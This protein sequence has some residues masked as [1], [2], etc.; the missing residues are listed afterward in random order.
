M[1]KIY[2]FFWNLFC[3]ANILDYSCLH[4]FM[5][6]LSLDITC[7]LALHAFFYELFLWY[8]LIIWNSEARFRQ[9]LYPHKN[10]RCVYTKWKMITCL[11]LYQVSLTICLSPTL[12]STQS[13]TYVGEIVWNSRG[14]TSAAYLF[15]FIYN[16]AL[17]E[18]F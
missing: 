7:H 1:Q 11:H 2:F 6:G 4:F 16:A 10:F 8:R 5:S 13:H 14:A 12:L 18:K 17:M 3:S 9:K 15:T